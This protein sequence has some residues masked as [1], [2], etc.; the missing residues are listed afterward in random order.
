MVTRQYALSAELK[1]APCENP[2]ASGRR[3]TGLLLTGVAA[4]ALF[5]CKP[6]TKA[7]APEIRPVRTIVADPGEAGETVVLTGHI[8]ADDEPA[9]ASALPGG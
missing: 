3:W 7:E 9:F 2:R 1:Q 8:R 6:D 4:L 5:G